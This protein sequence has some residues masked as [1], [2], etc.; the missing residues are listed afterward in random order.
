MK[1]FK[2]FLKERQT[3]F[4]TDQEVKQAIEYI[5]TRGYELKVSYDPIRIRNNEKFIQEVAKAL[6]A[7]QTPNLRELFKRYN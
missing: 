5:E 4:L 1:S 6:K 7:T 2:Q 3:G